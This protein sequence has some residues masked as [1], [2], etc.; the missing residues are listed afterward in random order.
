M[1]VLLQIACAFLAAAFAAPVVRAQAEAASGTVPYAMLYRTLKP[2]QD[3]SA[4]PRLKVVPHISSHIPG[5]K[6]ET[7]R[8]VVQSAAGARAVGVAPDGAIDFPMDDALLAENPTVSTNQPKGSLSLG[9]TL[10]LVLPKQPRWPCADVLAGLAES[11]PVITSMPTRDPS[12]A[13]RGLELFFPDGAHAQVVVRGRSE[14]LLLADENGRVVL[15][16][17]A[18]LAEAGAV[19]EFST[20][21][22]RAQPYLAP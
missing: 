9:V 22:L 8:L 6:P 4:Y 20:L 12:H 11:E 14:R 2:A 19:L 17:D 5:V 10:E 21:P 3:A 15:M 1:T 7:I 13:V 18:E 16:R